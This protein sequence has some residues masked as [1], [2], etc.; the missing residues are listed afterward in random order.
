MFYYLYQITNLVN[1]KIYV[2]VHKTNNIDDSYMGSGKVIKNAI[3]K[4]G[5]DNFK[6]EILESFNTS[7]DMYEKEKDV[8]NLEFLTREDT[9]NLRQ[10]GFGGFDYINASGIPKMLGKKHTPETKSKQGHIK[11]DEEL[12]QLSS[13]MVGNDFN[14]KLKVKGSEHPAFGKPKT[15]T[16]KEKLSECNLGIKHKTIVC[17]HC[18]KIGGERAIKRWHKDCGSSLNKL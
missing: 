9:Y 15:Q 12:L 6:K 10:G 4:Y 14:P 3:I 18:G 1:N 16:H 8:V 11:S 17:I 13:R 7:E 2:G 5:Y